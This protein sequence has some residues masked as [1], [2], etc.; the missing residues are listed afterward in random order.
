MITSKNK[1]KQTERIIVQDIAPRWNIIKEIQK[2]RNYF[3]FEA[4]IKT[5][6]RTKYKVSLTL[7]K[8]TRE[9]YCVNYETKSIFL[10]KHP[11]SN[12]IPNK[13]KLSIEIDEN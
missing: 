13:D 7:E 5:R 11:N 3:W 1:Q 8:R 9:N 6:N 10:S 12:D 4:Y 2:Q